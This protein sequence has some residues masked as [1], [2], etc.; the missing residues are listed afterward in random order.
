MDVTAA[1]WSNKQGTA[2]RS[3]SCGTWK[4]HWLKFSGRVWPSYCSVAG[5]VNAATVGGHI[6]NPVVTGER[7]VPLCDSCNKRVGVFSLDNGTML[8]PANKAETCERRA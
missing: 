7:I 8:V 2:V 5:C 1:G 4:A 3:C 6:I